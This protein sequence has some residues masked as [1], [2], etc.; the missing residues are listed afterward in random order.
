MV[1]PVSN[2]TTPRTPTETRPAQ[3]ESVGQG[4]PT[5]GAAAETGRAVHGHRGR[6]GGAG[7]ARDRYG[8]PIVQGGYVMDA[9][10]NDG[11]VMAIAWGFLVRVEF[12][13]HVAWFD[14]ADVVVAD[15]CDRC[16][17][18]FARGIGRCERHE[19]DE[20][21]GAKAAAEEETRQ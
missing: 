20:M 6:S 4:T 12:R 21:G 8:V 1:R 19:P 13:D 2:A 16:D 7:E 3:P 18:P 9:D 17:A 10:E 11:A 15:I 14:V 5:P